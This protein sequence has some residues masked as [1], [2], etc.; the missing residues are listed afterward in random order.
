[1]RFDPGDLRA[2]A[3][4]FASDRAADDFGQ[5]LAA[6]DIFISINLDLHCCS[7]GSQT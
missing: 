2:K 1:V 5:A 3:V 6:G 7:P 4:Q